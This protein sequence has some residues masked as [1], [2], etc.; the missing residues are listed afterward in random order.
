MRR[1]P[2]RSRRTPPSSKR[3]RVLAEYLH[4]LDDADLLAAT[5]FF[6][7]TP[8]AARD[9]RTLCVGGRTIVEVARRVWGFDDERLGASYRATGDLGA[10]LGHA[11][12]SAARRD[13]LRRS[14]NAGVADALFGEIAAASG[15]RASKRREAVLRTDLARVRRS[16][17]RDVRGEDRHRRSAG[18]IARRPRARCDR[19]GVRC[20]CRR[21]APRRR[22]SAGD[23][24]AVAL[25]AARLARRASRRLRHADRIHARDADRIRRCVQGACRCA[26]HFE[27]K[28]DGIRAQAHVRRRYG[29]ALF[30]PAQRRDGLVSGD[31]RDALAAA[32]GDAIFDGEIVAMRDGRALP[33][34]SF[35]RGSNGRMLDESLLQRR[36][37]RIRRLRRA[38][39]RRR[40][41]ARRAAGRASRASRRSRRAERAPRARAV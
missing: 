24:G 6:T 8:F 13:A 11:R 27:D 14:S 5:R 2:K 29:A 21:R 38:R 30:A 33:F 19:Q 18:R 4:G 1:P 32:R 35:K 20:R 37:D 39:R 9:H 3:L 16:A 7:G 15:K 10:A 40:A 23:V 36:P 22:W 41:L 26:W 31:R 12:A 34:R 28:Y 25:A 17:R